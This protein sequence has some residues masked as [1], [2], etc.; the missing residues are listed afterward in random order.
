MRRESHVET[1]V[2]MDCGPFVIARRLRQPVSFRPQE[3]LVAEVPLLSR[4]KIL[5]PLYVPLSR[6]Q[7][8]KNV[9][10]LRGADIDVHFEE[11]ANDWRPS[12]FECCVS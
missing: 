9:S 8:K 6:Q 12:V 11:E 3:S 2:E 5:C 1:P 7:W 10:S 4:D